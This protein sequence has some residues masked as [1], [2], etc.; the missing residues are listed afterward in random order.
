MRA[1]LSAE[2]ADVADRGVEICPGV[3][4]ARDATHGG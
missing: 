4:A 2:V 3:A 1:T